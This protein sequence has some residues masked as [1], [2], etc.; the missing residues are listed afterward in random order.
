MNNSA[1]ALGRF[2]DGFARALL[3]GDGVDD[4]L[5]S[6]VAQPGFSIYRNTVLKACNDALA[7]NYPAVLRLV[8]DEW[9]RAAAAVYARAHLPQQPMLLAYGAGFAQFLAVFEPAA[10]LPYLPGVAQLDRLWSEAHFARDEAPLDTD[11]LAQ[12]SPQQLGEL[13]LLPHAAARW[14]WFGEMPI[15]TIWQRNRD[16]VGDNM[17]DIDW[18][19]EGALILRPLGAIETVPLGAAGCAFLDACARGEVLPA[20]VQAAADVEGS[21]D[22]AELTSTL[23]ASGALAQPV[24][25]ELENTKEP[26]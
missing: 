1:S 6:V 26:R 17:A 7:A 16:A 10:A 18:R 8:G 9:F 5:A 19:G 11:W 25:S 12:Q 4:A 24:A 23:F 3:D 22:L 21:V 14:A 2:Q 20:A 15:R 13:R